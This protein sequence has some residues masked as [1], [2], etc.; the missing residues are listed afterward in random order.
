MKAAP[1]RLDQ[2]ACA[3][4][5]LPIALCDVCKTGCP[6]EAISF[7]DD[8]GA[9]RIDADACLGCGSCAASCPEVAFLAQVPP[10]DPSDRVWEIAC[11]GARDASNYCLNAISL[12]DLADAA[13]AGIRE[14][15]PAEYDCTGCARAGAPPF[16][17]T[18]ARF[19]SFARDRGVP[20][21]RLV[22]KAP[23][24]KGI[25]QRLIAEA[26]PDPGRRALLHGRQ[27]RSASDRLASLQDF[28]GEGGDEATA[29]FPFAPAIDAQRCTGCD[30][31]IRACPRGALRVTAAAPAAYAISANLC[32]GCGLCLAVCDSDAITVGIDTTAGCSVPLDAYTCSSCKS[33]SHRPATGADKEKGL[34]HICAG[35]EHVRPDNLVL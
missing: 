20:T 15:E 26:E 2:D 27:A 28:L 34:C 31:C 19:N 9:P 8:G 22:R 5:S 32:T 11:A 10:A 35:R 4:V 3:R 29:R 12:A 23:K 13:R 17:G 18:L 25:L 24:K 30:A 1:P 21:L 7:G 16:A 14:I 33:P 6:A